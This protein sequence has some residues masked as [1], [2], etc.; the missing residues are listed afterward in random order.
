MSRGGS[1]GDQPDW[2][3]TPP[4]APQL[5]DV[6]NFVHGS[7]AKLAEPRLGTRPEADPQLPSRPD[8]VR[9][10]VLV[11]ERKYR[12]SEAEQALLTTVGAF[13]AVAVN[14]LLAYPYASNPR[15]FGQDLRSLKGQELIRT[16]RLMVGGEDEVLEILVL[17]RE[18]KSLVAAVGTRKGRQISQMGLVKPREIVHDAALYRMYEAEAAHIRN[19]GGTVRRVVLDYELK[20][21]IYAALAKARVLPRVDYP[22]VQREVA[23][24]HGLQV[25]GGRILLPDLRMEYD[26]AE[27]APTKVDLELATYHYHGAY[28]LEKARVGFKLDADGPSAARLNARLTRG[29]APVPKGPGLVDAI[30]SL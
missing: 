23:Q 27:G 17:T 29:R 10:T 4:T 25:T 21:S 30:L 14:D 22:K 12:I 9:N 16:H 2:D 7:S 19:R 28:A 1:R 11:R 20:A 8:R 18:A 6:E 13:R 5:T 15:Q 26:T 3:T 24:A